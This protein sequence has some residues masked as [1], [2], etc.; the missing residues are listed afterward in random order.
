DIHVGY[1]ALSDSGALHDGRGVAAVA[2]DTPNRWFINPADFTTLRK[3]KDG[4]G[5][6]VIQPDI[7]QGARYA[8]HGIPVVV[9][10]K[11]PKGKVALVDM[12]Q[13]DV[14]RDTDPQVK[15]LEET[16]ASTDEIGIRHTSRYDIGL[17]SPKAVVVLCTAEVGG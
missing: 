6:Y 13:V 12:N 1:T 5:Q 3:V 4:T 10:N 14:V 9:S 7:T 11:V 17:I 16:Y 2:A 15:I 8:L